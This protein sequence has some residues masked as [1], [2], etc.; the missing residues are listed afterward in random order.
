[1]GQPVAIDILNAD[2][3][4]T[5]IHQF[6]DHAAGKNVCIIFP[7][8]GVK[9]SYYQPLA[10]ELATNGWIAFT[11]DLR[12]NGNSSIRPS[13]KVDFNYSDSLNQ[14]LLSVITYVKAENASNRLY[15]LGHSLGGQ[16]SC[17][18]A[19]RNEVKIDGLILSATC[20]VYCNGWD[21][22]AA[23]RILLGTQFLSLVANICGYLPGKKVGF[24]GTEAKSLIG[25]WSRQ[26]RT[27]K[28][29]LSNDPFNY[30]A[31]LRQV[32]LPVLA[33]SYEGDDL[34][35]PNA[36]EHLLGKLESAPKEHIHLTKTDSRNDG[37]NH[38]SWVKKP[39][40]IV[41]M[42]GEWVERNP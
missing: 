26:S 41:G 19:S 42:I 38:F 3:T 15:L 6:G 35:P 34:C 24:G 13:R 20:S 10:E 8:M 27:G 30:E 32:K 4:A 16:L 23:Y 31:A 9:A 36:V 33:I 14:D 18:F 1:M 37:F 29:L 28:Y 40:N 39:K 2:G 17:L 7:A 12:G 25:D 21:G 22:L 5:K 11:A